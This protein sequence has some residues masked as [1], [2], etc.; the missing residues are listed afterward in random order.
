MGINGAIF[1]MDYTDY[2]VLTNVENG[3]LP[4]G[5]PILVA[6]FDNAGAL[7]SK[8]AELEYICAPSEGL[9]ITSGIAYLDATFDKYEGASDPEFGIVDASGNQNPISPEWT[10]N[11]AC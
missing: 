8:G 6:I 2:Q 4:D 9:R 1:Y 3:T 11:I 7:T 5:T 10:F